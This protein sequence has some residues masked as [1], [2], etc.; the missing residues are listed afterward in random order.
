MLT[1]QKNF[2]GYEVTYK[3]QL[4]DPKLLFRFWVGLTTN[5]NALINHRE[6]ASQMYLICINYD[7]RVSLG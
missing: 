3:Q 1:P 7:M 2:D 4:K 6:V 5:Y